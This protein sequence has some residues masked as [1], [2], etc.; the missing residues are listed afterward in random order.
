MLSLSRFAGG[1]SKA[2]VS[3]FLS[4]EVNQKQIKKKTLLGLSNLA[5][6]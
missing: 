4:V 1:H 5:D 6:D 2:S 3:G